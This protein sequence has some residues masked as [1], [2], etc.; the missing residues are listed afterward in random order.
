MS[1]LIT[2]EELLTDPDFA[3]T[4]TLRRNAG[5]YN[6]YGEWVSSGNTDSSVVGAWQKAT[7]KE[8]V[9]IG[10]GEIKQEMRKFL[11][12]TEIK[13]SESDD[14]LSDR[15]IWNSKR[16][17][18]LKVGDNKDNGYYRAFAAFEGVES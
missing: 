4:L 1:Q 14:K 9:Q 16:Y 17:K 5:A 2:V 10:L 18:V 15:L 13:I 6:D 11:T 7:E 8:L 3:Q 12:T